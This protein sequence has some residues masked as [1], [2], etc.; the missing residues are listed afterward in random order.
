MFVFIVV[1]QIYKA[2]A[3]PA[4][5]KS[6]KINGLWFFV[7]FLLVF[8]GFLRVMCGALL[9]EVLPLVTLSVTCGCYG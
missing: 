1:V 2:G 4:F 7:G 5:V 9:W 6:F 8:D 3:V